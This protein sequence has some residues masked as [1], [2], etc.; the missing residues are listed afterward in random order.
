MVKVAIAGGTGAVGKTLVDVLAGQTKHQGMILTRQ[1]LIK[2]DLA[3]PYA[4]VNYDDVGSLTAVLEEHQVHT[5]ISAF[6]INGKSLAI[7]QINLIQAASASKVTQRFIPSSFATAYPEEGVK[8]LPPLQ[9]YFDSLKALEATDL[10]WAVV[11]NGIFMDYYFP[12]TLKSHYNHNTL[13]VDIPNHAA[14]IPGTGNERLTLTSIHDSARFVVAALG[15]SEWPRELRVVGDTVTYNELVR[16]A[17]DALGVTFD[18]KYD[19]LEKLKRFEVSELPGHRDPLPFLSIFE[20]WTAEGLSEVKSE[21]SLNEMFPEIKPWMVKDLMDQ[22][23]KGF[24]D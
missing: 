2:Q 5:V 21:G 15:L 11:H 23:W 7:S 22:H 16:L 13:V 17:E 12:R 10:E 14:A 3:L 9:S 4:V 8:I 18:I 1:E 20:R 24:R 6:G 19:D